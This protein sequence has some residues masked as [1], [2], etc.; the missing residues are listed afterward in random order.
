MARVILGFFF[1]PLPLPFKTLTPLRVKVPVL[2]R[3]LKGLWGY[4][5]PETRDDE[6][7]RRGIYCT[8]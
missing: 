4:D 5:T 3:V 7:H 8:L 6:H 1:V 2:I